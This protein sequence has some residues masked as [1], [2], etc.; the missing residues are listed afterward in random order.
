MPQRDMQH[1]TYADYLTW[2]GPYGD[3]LIDGVAFVREPPAPSRLHQEIV[4]EL[5]RQATTALEGKAGRVYVA[6]FD[7]R[8]PKCSESDEQIDTVVQPDELIVCDLHK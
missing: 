1:H 4:V 2:S 3:E 8:L 6:P 7:V 5:C